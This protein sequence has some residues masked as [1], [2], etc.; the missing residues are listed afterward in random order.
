MMTTA[1]VKACCDDMKKH[2]EYE[3]RLI[4]EDGKILIQLANYFGNNEWDWENIEITYC[5]F[6]GKKLEVE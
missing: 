1:A 2:L 6:C 5:M 4:V 3:D